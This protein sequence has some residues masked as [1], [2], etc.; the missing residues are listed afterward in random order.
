MPRWDQGRLAYNQGVRL[1]LAFG[2][3]VCATVA[4]CLAPSTNRAIIVDGDRIY[5]VESSSRV[6]EDLMKQAHVTLTSEDQLLNGGYEVDPFAA[7]PAG[8]PIYLQVRRPVRVLVNHEPLH[9]TS[10]TVGE[11]SAEGGT[12]LYVADILDPPA[13]S[14]L[15]ENLGISIQPSHMASLTVDTAG[16][17]LRSASPRLDGALADAGFPLIGLDTALPDAQAAFPADG[18]IRLARITEALVLVQ[19][20]IQY[21]S[22]A[23]DS[24]DVELGVEQIIEPGLSG[25]SVA[26][27]RIKYED[28]VEIS[29][30]VETQAVVRPPKDRLVVQGTRVVEK[31]ANVDGL[32]I[33]YWRALQM[34]ATVYSPCNS[35]TGSGACSSG[36]ASGLP[37]GKGVVAVDPALYTFLN[38][39]RLYI[40]GY[41]FAVVGDVGGGY[42]V[43]Q[44]LGISRYKWIDLGFD[45][46]NIQDL[47]G[48]ITVY[49]L[50]P[51]P[52]T[53][54]EVLK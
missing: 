26:R 43:E 14:P 31:T 51:A 33:Q 15:S 7:V 4:S 23:Q 42:I 28:G 25:L 21:K 49:F 16:A 40:P 24:P 2:L 52:A 39:Q 54:P 41:G 19:E 36:T 12:A 50:A 6:P 5:Q 3:S 30:Q 48:W 11:A 46:N 32:T 37:A 44:K 9:T 10:R 17:S 20:L 53:I 13:D 34:Y 8:N 1:R 22:K 38:G 45:D 47:T 35:A 29:R 18:Q 27:T